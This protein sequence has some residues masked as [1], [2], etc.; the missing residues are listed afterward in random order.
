MPRD[1]YANVAVGRWRAARST[2]SPLPVPASLSPAFHSRAVVD[3]AAYADY[4]T[5][6]TTEPQRN[7]PLVIRPIPETYSNR[8][9]PALRTPRSSLA[10]HTVVGQTEIAGLYQ[11]VLAVEVRYNFR[12]RP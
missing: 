3:V 11:T 12:N 5:L 7:G 9:P 4:Q 10:V 8:T 2:A 1:E 6:W